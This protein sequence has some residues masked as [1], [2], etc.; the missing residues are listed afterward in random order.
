MIF[1]EQMRIALPPGHPLAASETVEL[2][3]LSEDD[4]LC[5]EGPSSCRALVVEACRNAGFEPKPSFESDD[6]EVLKGLVAAGLGVTLLPE[7]AGG[8]PGIELKDVVPDPP[9]RRIWAVTREAPARAPATDAMVS[10]LLEVGE[11]FPAERDLRSV[12]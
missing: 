10:L 9:V 3:D 5:G 6:Y 4:W 1:Q 11:R 8:H 12:A 2:R 7:L